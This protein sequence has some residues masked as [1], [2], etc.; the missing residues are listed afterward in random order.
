MGVLTQ[1]FDDLDGTVSDEVQ[2]HTFVIDGEEVEPLD[3]RTVTFEAIS[4]LLR[5][6]D[7]SGLQRVFAP[8]SLTHRSREENEA[9]RAAART[10]KGENGEPLFDVKPTGRPSNAVIEWYETVYLPAQA[11]EGTAQAEGE[12]KAEGEGE[13]KADAEATPTKARARR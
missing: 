5:K 1:K 13:V 6:R 7:S 8:A 9:I 2:Q 12:S 10:A 3:L 11:A 4:D